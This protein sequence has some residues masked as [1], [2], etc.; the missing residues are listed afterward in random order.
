MSLVQNAIGKEFGK[1]TFK[2][3][4]AVRERY[5]AIRLFNFVSA[6]M[7]QLLVAGVHKLL[8]SHALLNIEDGSSDA[9]V[10]RA[11]LGIVRRGHA[12]CIGD[13]IADQNAFEVDGVVSVVGLVVTVA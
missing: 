12:D 1:A 2:G 8:H 3:L 4:G 13:T 6:S 7:L 5:I 11:R 10:A 9:I